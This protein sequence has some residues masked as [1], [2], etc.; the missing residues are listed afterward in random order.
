MGG[1]AILEGVM[2][3][4]PHGYSVTVRAPNGNMVQDTRRFSSLS[5]RYRVLGLPLIRGVVHLVESMILGFKTMDYAQKI[6][7]GEEGEPMEGGGFWM[8]IFSAFS[9]VAAL[10]IGILLLKVFPLWL[11]RSLSAVWPYLVEH[12]WALN[13]VDGVTKLT[14]FLSYLG[15]LSLL[16][17]IRR[18]FQYH[19]AE[20]KSIWA[21]DQGLPL[22]LESAR[23][24]TRFHPRCGTS[25]IFLVIVVSILIYT[26]VPS[27]TD[28]TGQ[29]ASRILSIPL[30]AGVSYEVLKL[31]AKYSNHLWARVLAWP[32]LFLQRLT[33]REPDDT[34]LEVALNSLNS[35]LAFE[36]TLVP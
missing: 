13:L 1:Q 29:L 34:Q 6:I 19:G 12:F 21:Y 3:R 8:G 31:S 4:S 17:D 5:T 26:V 15:V 9:F 2:M 32:G 35:A 33:T 7:L 10:A 30:I 16:P 25:F 27:P 36:A 24:Q 20:H 22:T 23:A 18:V 28:F 14:V 11:A